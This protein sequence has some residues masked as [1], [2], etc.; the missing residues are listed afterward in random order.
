MN[1]EQYRKRYREHKTGFSFWLDN[2]KDADII[3]FLK[4]DTQ[5]T[6]TETIKDAIRMMM[7]RR[8]KK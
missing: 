8:G 5:R 1:Y 7:K 6:R 4:G 2:D 3:A